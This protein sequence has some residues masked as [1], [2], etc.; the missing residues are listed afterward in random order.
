M[1]RCGGSD[2]GGGSGILGAA[3]CG[4]GSACSPDGRGERGA[5][6]PGRGAV[7]TER[8][9]SL[10][11]SRGHPGCAS[12]WCSRNLHRRH[13]GQSGSR[14]GPSQRHS[15]KPVE[16]GAP[17]APTHRANLQ[18]D[19]REAKAPAWP[20]LVASLLTSRPSGSL[21][22]LHLLGFYPA[23][24]CTPLLCERRRAGPLRESDTT[25]A[26]PQR[27]CLSKEEAPGSSPPA[28][29]RAFFF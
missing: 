9:L 20:P 7:R 16:M 29:L 26:C 18:S 14:E 27:Q 28:P 2:S 22:H 8:R 5:R 12:C 17:P 1:H 25:E 3:G 21:T 10:S 23:L 11:G 6:G 4:R 24:S 19:P 15:P 13:P